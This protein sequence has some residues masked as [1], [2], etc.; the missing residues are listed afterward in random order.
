LRHFGYASAVAIVGMVLVFIING[1]VHFA[2][3]ERH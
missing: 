3:R 1:L 2:I